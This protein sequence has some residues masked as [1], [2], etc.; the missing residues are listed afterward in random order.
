MKRFAVVTMLLLLAGCGGDGGDNGVEMPEDGTPLASDERGERLVRI[1][2]RAN[3]LHVPGAHVSYS[4]SA[5]GEMDEDSLFEPVSCEGIKCSAESAGVELDLDLSALVD[6]DIDL[7][8]SEANLQSR[9]GFDTAD[10]KGSLDLSDI[11]VHLPGITVTEIPEVQVYGFWGEH[12]M[13]GLALADGP[14]AGLIQIDDDDNMFAIPFDGHMKV[15]I[16]FALGAASGTNPSGTGS[17]AWTGIAEAVSPRTFMRREGIATLTVEDLSL[18]QP[19]VSV[20]IDIDGSPIDKPGWTDM[21]L[22][23]GHFKYGTAEADYLEGNFHGAEH[24]EAYGV[25]DTDTFTGAFG[26]KRQGES[27]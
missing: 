19:T 23:G 21:P 12:G 25:F 8:V 4:V 2:E 22:A 6:L 15:V 24:S 3:T 26:A 5:L 9:G 7:S 27:E 10:V 16:P 20:A 1:V 18:L 13:A 17:A 11:G 14:Y